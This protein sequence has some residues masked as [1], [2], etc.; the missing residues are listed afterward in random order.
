MSKKQDEN[1]VRNVFAELKNHQEEIGLKSTTT[2]TI[3]NAPQRVKLPDNIMVFQTFAF[4]AS[5]KLLPCSNKILMWF[6]AGVAYE[7]YI[8]VDVQTL[9]EDLN[10]SKKTI[11]TGLKE[12][13]DNNI[14]IKF[15]NGRDRRRHDYLINPTA[16]WRGHSTSRDA[17]IKKINFEDSKQLKMWN[18]E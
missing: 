8:G 9:V 13:E 5:R 12:L 6:F 2:V 1:L 15:K 16:A 10:M 17:Y 18:E 3:R 11:I 4:L 7:N 14:I